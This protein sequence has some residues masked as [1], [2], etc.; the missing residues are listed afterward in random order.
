MSLF[1]N[2]SAAPSGGSLFGSSPLKRS[3]TLPLSTDTAPRPAPLLGA[4][5]FGGSASSAASTPATTA[6]TT[7]APGLGGSLFSNLGAT[8]PKTAPTSLFSTAT[9]QPSA[10]NVFGAANTQ[11]Q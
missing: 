7:S 11:A 4:S 8:A 9:P 3:S 2:S 6:A 10:S 5:L 1:G